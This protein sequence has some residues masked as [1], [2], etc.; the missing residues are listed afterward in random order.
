MT[1]LAA[2]LRAIRPIP[3]HAFFE[4]TGV[5]V[6]M[7]RRATLVLEVKRQNFID[8]PGRSFPMTPDARDHGVSA[9]Q[10]E[11]RIAVH[12]HGKF[13]AV[14]IN[15]SVAGFTAI[16]VGLFR[17]LPIVSVPMAVRALPEFHLEKC[18]CPRGNM[19]FVAF[20]AGV[21]AQ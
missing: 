15:D 17:E 19:A 12:G 9:F 11:T 4:L 18:R 5:R 1:S 21:L 7:T 16:P 10:G 14:K 20:H 8:A 13:R 6:A 2:E 3:F